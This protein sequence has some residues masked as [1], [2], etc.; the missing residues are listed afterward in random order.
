MTIEDMK[1]RDMNMKLKEAT[2]ADFDN[3]ALHDP[4][5]GIFYGVSQPA[6]NRIRAKARIRTFEP[7]EVV[8]NAGDDTE[9]LPVYVILSGKFT[10][11][12]ELY[13]L[14]L[15]IG[16]DEPGVVL[17]DVEMFVRDVDAEVYQRG[18]TNRALS[19]VVCTEAATA[20]MISPPAILWETK[21]FELA[22]NMGKLVCFKL[23]RRNKRTAV[24]SVPETIRIVTHLHELVTGKYGHMMRRPKEAGWENL[25]EKY[26]RPL[27][28]GGK[29][30]QKDVADLLGIAPSTV[31]NVAKRLYK[32]DGEFRWRPGKIEMTKRFYDTLKDAAQMETLW[33]RKTPAR[34]RKGPGG[35]TVSPDEDQ[36]SE[37][38]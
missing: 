27:S 20:L 30:T 26:P 7:D 33:K 29:I 10:A 28:I 36:T 1:P 2:K 22:R 24:E 37:P 18:E 4:Q 23:L 11:K 21:S 32:H 31:S 17:A 14:N 15:T 19:T 13:G 34:P 16:S 3:P 9:E 35:K 12:H 8:F 25:P 5:T 38:L 6:L